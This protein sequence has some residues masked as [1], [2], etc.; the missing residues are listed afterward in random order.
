MPEG[1]IPVSGSVPPATAGAG[2]DQD[3]GVSPR[4]LAVI[5]TAAFMVSA[6][7]RV[8]SPLL[9][10]MAGDFNISTARAG[11]FITAYT[12]PYGLFQLVYGPL[13]DRWSRQQV[14]GGALC[15]F[16]L[17]TLVS[18][19]APNATALI[20]LRL[21]TGAAAAGVIPIALAFIGD[22][23]PYAERQAALG[24]VV[25][26]ASLG[27][28][29]SAALGGVI[30]TI[31][32]WQTLFIGYGFIAFGVALLLLRQPLY[33]SR[34]ALRRS[35]GLLG[36]YR[37]VF[38]HAGRRAAALYTLVFLEGLAATGVVGYL[39][40]F[41]FER[42]HL[43]YVTIGALLTIQGIAQ[44]VT[45]RVVGRIVARLGERGMLLVGGS[46]LVLAYVLVGLRPMPI[47]FPLAMVLSG[48][49]FVIAHSTL[50][51]RATELVPERRGT[52]VALFAFSLF[53][54]GGLGTFLAGLAIDNVGFGP[55]LLGAAAALASFTA[56]S[57]P[58]LGI[59]RR[60]PA[61]V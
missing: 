48:T 16:A 55:T 45:G 44:I 60:V 5:M 33:R 28:V 31:A 57:W 24:R 27:G 36:P 49:G 1:P 58:L 38:A 34:P 42:D 4:L 40:A 17:G 13:A 46:L 3:A 39:G 61:R 8:I 47:F 37:E 6:E 51:V 25:S 22:A 53:L 18:G 10:A 20:L 2:L 43:P 29:L 30:A 32:S 7:M 9:P 26:V 11:L 19:F 35:S 56:I 15:L 41:L 52:A 14:M 50:Q 12:L 54:G 23:V 21:F 59:V